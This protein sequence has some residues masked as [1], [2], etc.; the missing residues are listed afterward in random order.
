MKKELSEVD[1]FMIK[2]GWEIIPIRQTPHGPEFDDNVPSTPFMKEF[3]LN[4]LRRLDREEC[5]SKV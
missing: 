4:I 1:K 3:A 5:R 2:S